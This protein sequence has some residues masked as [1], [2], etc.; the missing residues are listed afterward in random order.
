M[1][2]FRTLFLL[3]P[4]I[5]AGSFF[6]P[7]HAQGGAALFLTPF[8]ENTS[9]TATYSEAVNYYI[10]LSEAY[11]EFSF[12]T[13]GTTDSGFPLHEGV[14]S[15]D[16]D[17]DP[18]SLRE[19][20][21]LIVMVLNAIHPGEPCGVDASMMLVRDALLQPESYGWSDEV[22]LVVVPVYNIGGALNR[23]SHSRANQNGP[24]EYGFRGNARNLDLNRDFIKC[25]SRNAQSFN[26]L[27]QKWQPD[28]LIDNH[29]SNG[30]DYQYTITLLPPQ[31]DKLEPPLGEF[32]RQQ[33]LPQVYAG[34]EQSG[35]GLT[36]YVNAWPTPEYGIYG[37]LDLPRYS[38][39]YA[40]LFH[41]L[42]FMPEA[43]MLK[44][45]ED[46]VRSTYDMMNV[47]LG[48]AREQKSKLQ[49]ARAEARRESRRKTHF[50]LQWVRDTSR[51]DSLLFAGYE[52]GYK[53]SE[54]SGQPR[55]YYDRNKPWQ[56]RIPY[57]QYFRSTL[58]VEKPIAYIIPQAYTE[59]I[60]R[61]RWNGIQLQQ[62]A[63]DQEI[64]VEMYYIEDFE[65]TERPYE[66]H[67]LHSE[68]QVSRDTAVIT[69]RAGD[70]LIYTD[71][72]GGRYLLETLEPQAPDSWFCWNFFDGILMQKEY[73]SAYVFEDVA[74][75]LLREDEDLRKALEDRK[76][77][78]EDFAK[79]ARAQLE[80]VY[81]RSL[82]YE[83]THRRYPVWRLVRAQDL[84]LE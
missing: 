52:A 42:A 82:W 56:K 69:V 70:Y 9:I 79:S 11:D 18:A 63:A 30:A 72:A 26:R 60:E 38:S 53:P 20:G 67:Y 29:T 61:L 14:L 84:S 31:A 33:F 41:T 81:K 4:G 39:G 8:E 45:F 77:E 35:W 37:F 83:P 6:T 3:L 19:K 2:A 44:P 74:A 54:V 59:V 21:R 62:L 64:E 58:S 65:T 24:R 78:D 68:V 36:P 12:S 47:L 43:H 15:P 80:F 40:G 28:L 73:F 48:T 50:P 10:Q 34:M 7:L 17:M 66:G 55:L 51:H 22:V 57:Y 23:S 75:E 1:I 76:A 46:R 71:Q 49:N 5:L 32:L 25:D 27:F 16:G 13:F